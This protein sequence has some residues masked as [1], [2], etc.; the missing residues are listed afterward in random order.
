MPVSIAGAFLFIVFVALLPRSRSVMV[1]R[2]RNAL[3]VAVLVAAVV[4]E[5]QAYTTSH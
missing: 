1:V 2:L 4:Y 3:A 5:I